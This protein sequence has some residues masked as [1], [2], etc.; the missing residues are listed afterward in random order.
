MNRGTRTA[1]VVFAFLLIGTAAAVAKG[2]FRPP[3][4]PLRVAFQVCNSL[5]ENRERFEPLRA[6]LE[7]ELGRKVVASHV[8]TF[9]FADRARSREFDILQANGYVYIDVKEKLGA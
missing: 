3:L 6:W 4:P 9:D 5:E 1:R 8:N 2:F 7:R